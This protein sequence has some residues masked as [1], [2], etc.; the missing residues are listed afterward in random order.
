MARGRLEPGMGGKQKGAGRPAQPVG[1]KPIKVTLTLTPD[2]TRALDAH[3]GKMARTE[4]V[5][6]LVRDALVTAKR[7]SLI[8]QIEA[9]QPQVDAMKG[10]DEMETEWQHSAPALQLKDC[11]D[12]LWML[13]RGEQAT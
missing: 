8:Q 4:S 10:E 13:E 2:E 6:V 12:Q 7:K 9:L 1:D 11:L 5:M 3:R